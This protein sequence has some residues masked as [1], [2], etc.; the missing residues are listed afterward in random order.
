MR[1]WVLRTK[2]NFECLSWA[3]VSF[4]SGFLLA[5]YL[6]SYLCDLNSRTQFLMV[7]S[8][9][10]MSREDPNVSWPCIYRKLHLKSCAQEILEE[11]VCGFKYSNSLDNDWVHQAN[12]DQCYSE[13][14]MGR[15]FSTQ[16]WPSQKY[17][18]KP[19][20][21][22]SCFHM[23]VPHAQPQ[24]DLNLQLCYE[25]GERHSSPTLEWCRI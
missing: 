2:L 17:G 16:I 22:L 21:L 15:G 14:R 4:S 5:T 20:A 13:V 11:M 1:C 12:K 3:Q 19:W 23:T 25:W 8:I 9:G 6:F 24:R 7:V 18:E 10:V